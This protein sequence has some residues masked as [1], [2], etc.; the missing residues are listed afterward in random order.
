MS[1]QS[2]SGHDMTAIT[3]QRLRDE[4]AASKYA[5]DNSDSFRTDAGTLYIEGL[6]VK[7]FMAGCKHALS[8]Q[9]QEV[10]A[11][12]NSFDKQSPLNLKLWLDTRYNATGDLRYIHAGNALMEL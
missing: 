2:S 7:A 10:G 5:E 4:V 12:E 11:A 1:K 9:P 8:A 6:L 3:E